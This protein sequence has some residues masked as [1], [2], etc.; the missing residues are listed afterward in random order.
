MDMV[1]GEDVMGN[2]QA[3]LDLWVSYIQRWNQL[4]PELPLYSNIYVTVIPSWLHGYEQNALW[5][6]QSAILYATIENAE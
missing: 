4:L 1:Y 3:Y 6:L 5:G 2:E